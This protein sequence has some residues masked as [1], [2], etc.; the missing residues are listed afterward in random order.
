MFLLLIFFFSLLDILIVDIFRLNALIVVGHYFFEAVGDSC[1][2]RI[3]EK[4]LHIFLLMSNS[5]NYNPL[6]CRNQMRLI[7]WR[8]AH[9]LS[10]VLKDDDLAVVSRVIEVERLAEHVFQNQHFS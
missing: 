8:G 10:I 5:I 3:K 1:V 2:K 6:V 9:P 4:L 7:N